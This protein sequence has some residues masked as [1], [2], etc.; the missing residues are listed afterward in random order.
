MP[1][2]RFLMAVIESS[3]GTPKTS[4]TLGT[5]SFYMRLD[6]DNAF[7]VRSTAV[8]NQI[9][10]G[11]GF[12]TI[13]DTSCDEVNVAGSFN[14]LLYPGVWSEVLLKWAITAINTG[15]TT[16]WTTTDASA[17]MP[18]GDLASLSFYEAVLT[19]DGSTFR[20]KAFR[21][22]KCN[23]WQLT[24]QDNG[25]GRMW[26]LSGTLTGI[27]EQG[28][29]WDSSTDP[30]ATEFPV[31]AETSYPFG[32]FVYSHLATGTGTALIGTGNDRKASI[33]SLTISGTNQMAGRKATSRFI[34]TNRFIGR[35][36]TATAVIRYKTTPDDQTSYQTLAAQAVKF[37]LDNATKSIELDLKGNNVLSDWVRQVPNSDEYMQQLTIQNRWDPSAATDVGLTLA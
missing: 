28:S 8:H 29:S 14:F 35:N 16:P 31:P 3:F 25:E 37:K 26:R 19:Q 2:R 20:R 24:G 6:T 13:A 21:G 10:Y 7:D 15:R 32:P 27:R 9:Q 5:D 34:T 18:A 33:S 11:G 12:T 36:V 30:D 1:A 17:V 23:T 22:C 4:P